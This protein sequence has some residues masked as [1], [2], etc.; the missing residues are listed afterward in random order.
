MNDRALEMSRPLPIIVHMTSAHPPYDVRIFHRECVSLVQAGYPVKL[1]VPHSH[2]EEREGVRICAVAKSK[3]RLGRMLGSVWA[4]FR[5]ALAEKG[6]IYHFHD[7]ELIP[8]GLL[9][10][11]L[12]K[13]VVY[14]VH[15]D[16]PTDIQSKVWIPKPLRGL[17]AAGM[18]LLERLAGVLLSGIVAVTPPIA[19]R[20]PAQKTILLQNF[21]HPQEV[22]FFRNRSYQ[23]RPFR[24]LY[25]GSITRVRGLMEMVQAMEYL[26]N[27]SLQ[28]VLIGEFAPSNLRLEVEQIPGFSRVEYLGY[29]S[30]PETLEVLAQ[31]RIGLVVL[32]PIPSFLVSQPTKMYE[33][34]MAGIPFVASDFPLWRASLNGEECGLFVNPLDPQAIAKAIRWLLDHPEEAE[35]MGRRGRRLV[36]ERLNW[37]VEFTKL[38]EL[39]QRLWQPKIPGKRE[40]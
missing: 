22:A 28:L 17:I 14:D 40:I 4:V 5:R 12:G 1:V 30:R 38:T 2:D 23:E 15:E 13:R 39:Y 36:E 6:D 24:V 34:M 21:P 19:A 27:H 37:G 26:K 29:K 35:A 32:H 3:G 9:L 8:A 16:V 18:R 20:F 11:L 31:S 10:R 33:Y 7:P 25:A